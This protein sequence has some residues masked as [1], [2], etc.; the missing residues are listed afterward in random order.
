[1]LAEQPV[2][3]GIDGSSATTHNFLS[4]WKN[5]GGGWVVRSFGLV[6][7]VALN[8]ILPCYV[9]RLMFTDISSLNA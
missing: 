4:G 2:G 7:Q 9:E 5:G 8:G 6:A 1:M 3:L